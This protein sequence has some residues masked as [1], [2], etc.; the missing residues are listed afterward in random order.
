M[1]GG[2]NTATTTTGLPD[3]ARPYVEQSLGTAQDI[4]ETGGMNHVEG[5][6]PE[7]ISAGKTKTIRW[8]WWCI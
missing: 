2:G 5:L 1:G 4:Y 3:W 6:N 8:S 7:Q